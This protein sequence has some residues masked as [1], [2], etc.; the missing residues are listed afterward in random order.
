MFSFL[1]KGT[2]QLTHLKFSPQFT[3]GIE[4]SLKQLGFYKVAKTL[5][6]KGLW[7]PFY[8]QILSFLGDEIQL[9]C[10]GQVWLNFNKII[11]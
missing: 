3:L 2:A 10:W 8:I 1:G 9:I 11:F 7:G 4:F 6:L 5:K